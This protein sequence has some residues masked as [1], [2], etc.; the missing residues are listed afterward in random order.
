MVPTIQKED[1][2]DKNGVRLFDQSDG[3]AAAKAWLLVC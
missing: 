3:E 2:H 1:L